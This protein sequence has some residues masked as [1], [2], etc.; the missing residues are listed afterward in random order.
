[1][2]PVVP[3]IVGGLVSGAAVS[4]GVVVAGG[5]GAAAIGA[6]TSLAVGALMGSKP[7][8]PA[9]QDKIDPNSQI[10]KLLGYVQDKYINGNAS[11][12]INGPSMVTQ[13]PASDIRNT[14]RSGIS[15]QNLIYGKMLVG[16]AIP[17]WFTNG[18]RQQYHHFAQ[19][20]AGHVI[21][22]VESV[23]IGTELVQVNS[24]G[25]VSTPKYTR[26]GKGLIRFGVYHG[27]QTS[28]PAELVSASAGALKSGD[29]ATGIAWVY[30]R[31]EADYDV[32]GQVGIPEFRFVVKGKKLYDPRTGTTYYSDNPA[33]VA[34][35]YLTSSMGLRCLASE[36][37]NADVI[38]S[39][40]ICDENVLTPSG[41]TQKRY[42]INGAL[43]TENNLKANLEL[44]SFA[45]SGML[46]W[47]Q[48][49]WSIQAGAYQ[50]PV[51][52][53]DEDKIIEVENLT[54]F[55]ARRDIFNTVTGTFIA[56]NDWYVE[57]QFPVVANQDFI[58]LDGEK[59]ERNINYPLITDATIS[60]RLAKIDIMRARQA[61]TISMIC[62]YKA[63]DLRPG[64]HVYLSIARYGW[65]N[66]VFY[67][68][69]RTMSENG[70]HYT[71]RETSPAVWDWTQFE[72]QE[73]DPAPNTNLPN[74]YVVPSVLNL[75]AESGNS[76]LY[77]ASDGTVM[78]R[79]KCLWTASDNQY[80]YSGGSVELQYT[81][82]SNDWASAKV[83]G[84]QSIAFL[85][86]VTDQLLYKVRARYINN[87]GQRGPW[88]QIEHT[89][90]GKS[91]PPP[92][93][94][95]FTIEQNVASWSPVQNTP[96]LA[97]YKI[98]FQ[99]GQNLW[100]DTATPLHDG[101]LTESPYTF[102]TVPNGP[103]TLLIK[104]VD[105]SGNESLN[106]AVITQNLGDV[107]VS[108]LLVEY[109][110][111]PLWT[112]TK[113]NASV[114]AGE[115]VAGDSNLFYQANDL[116]MYDYETDLFY[117][118]SQ[119]L[120]MVYE[121]EVVAIKDSFL[122]LNYSFDV[123]GFKIE[124]SLP[125]QSLFY[126]P[127]DQLMYGNDA[128]LFYGPYTDFMPWTGQYFASEST[129]VLIRVTTT[130]GAGIDKLLELT[131]LLDV[132]DI[133]IRL[134]DVV[135]LS[136][137]TRLNLGRAVNAVKNVQVTVQAD[138]NNGIN[139]R[140]IDKSASNGPLIEVLNS[141]GVA[142]NGLIDAV[143]QAY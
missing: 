43:S 32:F 88:T 45:M 36:I 14:I 57:K 116:P 126:S 67:V 132:A 40:N 12:S 83:D 1:M 33:L 114:I 61:V 51:A 103:T 120:P 35:D 27:N 71:F 108:N 47:S 42:S 52:T 80:I 109:P 119:S 135:I 18:D 124:Y 68:I 55:S 73:V 48:G 136:T 87:T 125:S 143:I 110:Q 133:V 113:T 99:Y 62:N 86:P 66:K 78:S 105:T 16:G 20:L 49:Q 97:G 41:T 138:G 84:D 98:R 95:S 65:T 30:I 122:K 76:A 44:I 13:N 89:V 93:V 100:W 81:T 101:L 25:F 104:A 26:D 102:A 107:I 123:S 90:I 79:I 111:H 23:Y 4:A 28:L 129:Q 29:C 63:Y 75:K 34:R 46:F 69:E 115:L 31:W 56:A 5:I 130:G 50:T 2:P 58:A 53:I 117:P 137:G 10:G 94:T 38:A 77:I 21:E 91:E 17:W 9:T 8:K 82:G 70:I 11:A 37:N 106:P 112:G 59:I 60:Q 131:A 121:F 134:D 54:A 6:G 118:A 128:D 64:S 39:A 141:S 19:V 127:D 3:V 22:Q 96:D 72:A 7:K 140:V 15:P 142:V 92:D 85:A 24:D 139:A 74:P